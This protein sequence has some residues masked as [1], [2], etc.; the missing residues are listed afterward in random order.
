MSPGPALSTGRPRPWRNAWIVLLAGCPGIL[1]LAAVLPEVP[2]VPPAALLVQ[3]AFLLAG[4]AFAGTWAAARCGFLLAG[5]FRPAERVGQGVFGLLL[6]LLIAL[7]D[8]ATRGFWQAA[9]GQPPSVLE[10]WR[11]SALLVGVLYGGVVE[12]VLFRWGALSLIALGLRQVLA[13]RVGRPPPWCVA[14][15]VGLAALL[16]AASHLPALAAG[17]VMPGFGA[18]VRTVLLNAIAGAVFGLLF[19]MRDLLAAMVSHGA[20]HLGFTLAAMVRSA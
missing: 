1:S 2:G 3:P 18:A 4:L 9:P 12:E 16:F 6:G 8:H 17:G 15:A 10:G 13:R 19:A 5:G 20:A 7:A 11:P 14:I